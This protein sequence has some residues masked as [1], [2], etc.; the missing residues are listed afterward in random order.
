MLR[1]K[2]GALRRTRTGV[3]TA[4]K[5]QVLQG[6]TDLCRISEEVDLQ[7]LMQCIVHMMSLT[8]PSIVSWIAAQLRCK[9][10]AVGGRLGHAALQAVAVWPW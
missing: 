3:R 2:I 5:R 6:M 9:G 4:A 1:T 10:S 7:R 8:F